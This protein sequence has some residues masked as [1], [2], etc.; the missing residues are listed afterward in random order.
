[1]KTLTL[2]I[3]P[4]E[5]ATAEGLA[6]LQ[7]GE[8]ARVRWLDDVDDA[9]PVGDCGAHMLADSVRVALTN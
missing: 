8:P 6:C 5:E 2:E 1:M 7:C 3:F 4:I 9:T